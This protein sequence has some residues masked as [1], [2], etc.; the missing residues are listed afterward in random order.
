MAQANAR[1]RR[2]HRNDNENTIDYQTQEL[3]LEEILEEFRALEAEQTAAE[4]ESPPMGRLPSKTPQRPTESVCLFA[5]AQ[6]AP[7]R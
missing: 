3:S 5:S 1:R 7:R 6:V 2:T 4:E